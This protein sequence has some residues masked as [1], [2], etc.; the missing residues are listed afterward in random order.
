MIS[1]VDYSP[2]FVPVGDVRPRI[3]H[4]NDFSPGAYVQ[5]EPVSL[6]LLCAFYVTVTAVPGT[7][8]ISLGTH[9]SITIVL[10]AMVCSI[11]NL[12]V[13]ATVTIKRP[14]L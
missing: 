5:I 1:E 9:K 11:A 13:F 12:P 7:L 3:V 10:M 2:V 4:A 8:F 6:R 14:L